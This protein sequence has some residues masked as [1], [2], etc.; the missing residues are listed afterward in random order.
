MAAAEIAKLSRK[1]S[2]VVDH[3]FSN[4]KMDKENVGGNEWT[5]DR[6]N[7]GGT[8]SLRSISNLNVKQL[9][10][11][12][13]KTFQNVKVSFDSFSQKLRRSTRRRN[14]LETADSPVKSTSATTPVKLYS[15]FKIETPSSKLNNTPRRTTPRRRFQPFHSFES[16]SQTFHKDVEA[17]NSGNQQLKSIARG[18]AT[19]RS[20]K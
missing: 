7:S 2:A 5:F 9:K 12:A 1:T 4:C 19:Q 3:P 10:T 20:L 8:N 16:P 11:E 18:I 17:F 14:R 15:P 13:N 6:I